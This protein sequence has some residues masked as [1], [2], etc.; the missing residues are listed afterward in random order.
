MKRAVTCLMLA[1]LSGALGCYHLGPIGKNTTR[2]VA[3][4][5]FKNRTLKP[6][7]EAQITN[8]I[9]KRLQADGSTRVDWEANADVVVTGVITRYDRAVLRTQKEDTNVPRE[10]RLSIEALVEARNRITGAV[11]LKPTTLIG[12]ADSF[13]GSDLQSAEEQALPLIADDLA[14]RVVSLLV[15]GW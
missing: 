6:Q 10:Y 12:H 11:V 5:M 3:V 1:W 15:E 14:R 8:A 4:P 7:L 13:L 2:S 9:I